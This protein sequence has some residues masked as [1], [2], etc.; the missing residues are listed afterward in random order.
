M[1][2]FELYKAL[3][4]RQD[5]KKLR[6]QIITDCKIS[7]PTFYS[8]MDREKVPDEKSQAIISDLLGLPIIELFP[9]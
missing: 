1:N 5:Q 7:K 4:T 6:H 2:F 9:E 3:P 8:W